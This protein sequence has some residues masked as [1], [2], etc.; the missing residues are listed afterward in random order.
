[1]KDS[2]NTCD[3]KPGMAKHEVKDDSGNSRAKFTDEFFQAMAKKAQPFLVDTTNEPGP[4]EVILRAG[5]RVLSAD[6]NVL[7]SAS[8]YFKKLLS[9]PC[10][11]KSQPKIIDFKDD[12]DPFFL[13]VYLHLA[14]VQSM[15][16]T[17]RLP[18]CGTPTDCRWLTGYV[19]VYQLSAKFDNSELEITIYNDL[20]AWLTT[21]DDL[22]WSEEDISNSELMSFWLPMKRYADFT[23]RIKNEREFVLAVAE[24][25]AQ[26][27]ADQQTSTPEQPKPSDAGG[28]FG[29]VCDS[30]WEAYLEDLK[31]VSQTMATNILSEPRLSLEHKASMSLLLARSSQ[32]LSR[33]PHEYIAHAIEAVSLYQQIRES[34][35]AAEANQRNCTRSNLLLA[36][37]VLNSALEAQGKDDERRADNATAN[38]GK[39]TGKPHAERIETICDAESRTT[40]QAFNPQEQ[41]L[42]D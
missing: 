25:L 27:V 11:E 13:G 23:Y 6:E 14:Y 9:G 17:T 12:I 31:E 24:N 30:A 41:G 36:I 26:M 37:D 1:M 29:H 20:V 18:K 28:L 2:S 34:Q 5:G 15:G 39:R 21:N 38:A 40:H 4:G 33:D 35:D 16:E 7:T 32:G 19:K 42:L 8:T 3:E 10:E 22:K